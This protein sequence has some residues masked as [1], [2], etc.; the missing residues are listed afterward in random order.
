MQAPFLGNTYIN[1]CFHLLSYR[2]AVDQLRFMRCFYEA[3]TSFTVP[4]VLCFSGF[5]PIVVYQKAIC[6][7]CTSGKDMFIRDFVAIY[8]TFLRRSMGMSLST[9][10]L[11]IKWLL[12]YL[13]SG[14]VDIKFPDD[15][16]IQPK[17]VDGNKLFYSNPVVTVFQGVIIPSSRGKNLPI[18]SISIVSGLV[19]DESVLKRN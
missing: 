18:N 17:D 4:F 10:H 1:T 2:I 14:K 9:P 6:I 13:R 5:K 12:L 7:L 3:I 15:Q 19:A 8:S 11:P 16:N